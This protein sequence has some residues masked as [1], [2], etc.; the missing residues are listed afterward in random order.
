MNE[1][2]KNF[3][4][5][6]KLNNINN[7]LDAGSGKTS[8]SYLLNKFPNA[9]VDAI[10]YPGDDRKITSIKENVNGKYNLKELDLCN[11]K[12][13]ETYDLVF[14]HLLLGEATKFGNKFT[15]I[16]NRLLDINSKYFLIYD[17]KEDNM[18]DYGF[19]EQVLRER[20]FHIIKYMN[21]AKEIE[22]VFT[23]FVGT[24]YVAYLIE[25]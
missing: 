14:A 17:F 7:I 10:V 15:D 13:N 6:I 22:Q 24:N 21:F 12:I 4:C 16:L 23:D 5:L 2:Y 11:A 19:I 9:N 25:K 8:L 18:L 3:D 20:N 1:H